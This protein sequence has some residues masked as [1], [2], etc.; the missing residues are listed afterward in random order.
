[1]QIIFQAMVGTWYRGD[2]G[3]C[4]IQIDR[5]DKP[6]EP[7]SNITTE[8]PIETTPIE[9]TPVQTV[10]PTTEPTEEPTTQVI[11]WLKF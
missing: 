7:S 8:T 11:S 1:M 4:G 2:I 5:C 6:V 10:E 9:T 3:I